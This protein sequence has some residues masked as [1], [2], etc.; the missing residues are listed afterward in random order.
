VFAHRGLL[1][2]AVCA[3]H[4]ERAL[5][6][7]EVF[8]GDLEAL[9]HL[10]G[11]DRA[12]LESFAQRWDLGA[13]GA[14]HAEKKAKTSQPWVDVVQS[15]PLVASFLRVLREADPA[16]LGAD[17]TEATMAQDVTPLLG[18]VGV[19][20]FAVDKGGAYNAAEARKETGKKVELRLCAQFE[21]L[22]ER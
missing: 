21:T 10:R 3:L 4:R 8:D 11:H 13:D 14:Q 12:T 5:V 15:P 6:D 20:D 9:A 2:Q 7:A 19:L 17:A 22:E 16:G 1:V 18:A